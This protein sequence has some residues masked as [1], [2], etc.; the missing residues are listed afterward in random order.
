M[1]DFT[2]YIR[3]L[4]KKDE[5]NNMHEYLVIYAVDS[6]HLKKIFLLFSYYCARNIND[7]LKN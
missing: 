6:Y 5:L 4:I 2:E 7:S 3:I 1:C